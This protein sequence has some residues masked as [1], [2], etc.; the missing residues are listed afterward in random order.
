MK[1]ISTSHPWSFLFILACTCFLVGCSDRVTVSGR[2]TFPDG[3]PLTIGSIVFESEAHQAY[4]YIG[5]DGSYSLGEVEPG[6]GVRPGEYK[7]RILAASGGGS[8][9]SPLVQHVHPKYENTVTSELFYTVNGK[10][11]INI[12]V[13]K[14]E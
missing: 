12:T 11:E 14:P 8:D 2:I 3:E 10:M 13:E 5:A 6:D 9:G 4:S 7:V 1:V